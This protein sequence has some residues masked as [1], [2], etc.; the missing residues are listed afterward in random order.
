M[1]KYAGRSNVLTNQHLEGPFGLFGEWGDI[2]VRPR[3]HRDTHLLQQCIVG[4]GYFIVPSEQYTFYKRKE[5]YTIV[6]S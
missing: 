4:T 3:Y 5:G 2:E 6:K 1:I